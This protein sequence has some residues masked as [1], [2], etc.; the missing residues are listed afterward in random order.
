MPGDRIVREGE[1]G[2]EMYFIQD[3]VVEVTMKK[4][5]VGT[6]H[7]KTEGGYEKIYLEKGAYFGEV[8]LLSNSKRSFDAAAYEFCLLYTFTRADYE[9]LRREFKDI[10]PRLR[11]GLKHYKNTHMSTLIHSLQRLNIFEGFTESEVNIFEGGF[12]Y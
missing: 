2:T 7:K 8:A 3:G 1:R 6:N 12:L 4:Q 5:V 9:N 10:G 11:S